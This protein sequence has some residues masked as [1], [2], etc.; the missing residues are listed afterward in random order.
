[1]LSETHCCKQ[2]NV[3]TLQE[4]GGCIKVI[5]PFATVTGQAPKWDTA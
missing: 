4:Y 2:E 5:R 3:F 1:M